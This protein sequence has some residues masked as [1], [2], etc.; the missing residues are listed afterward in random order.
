MLASFAINLISLPPLALTCSSR[1][2]RRSI[3]RW[4]SINGCTGQSP[5]TMRMRR[6]MNKTKTSS[7]ASGIP[8][9]TRN[10]P[11]LLLQWQ[12]RLPRN[13][14]PT[15]RDESTS[16]MPALRFTRARP[17]VNHPT[18]IAHRKALPPHQT[19]VDILSDESATRLEEISTNHIPECGERGQRRKIRM[20]MMRRRRRK[21]IDARI[22]RGK[23]QG[24]L[25]KTSSTTLA[26]ITFAMIGLQ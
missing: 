3:A 4:T 18:L 19:R 1:A 6:M 20:R 11:Y 7:F 24:S 5:R 14:R 9:D 16:G 26:Q 15:M 17:V 25:V 2:H 10:V 13:Q 23:K 21:G 12:A 22:R 8:G